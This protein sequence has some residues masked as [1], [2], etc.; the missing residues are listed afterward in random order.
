MSASAASSS[1]K[2]ELPK[3]DELEKVLNR[4]ARAFERQVEVDR[5]LNAFK[6][7]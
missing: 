6:L 3:N 2:V 4:E 5:I 1:S 7:K